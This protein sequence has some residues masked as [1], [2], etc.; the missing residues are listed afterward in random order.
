MILNKKNIEFKWFKGLL[1]YSSNYRKFENTGIRWILGLSG[2]VMV[3]FSLSFAFSSFLF[4]NIFLLFFWIFPYFF[5]IF[6]YFFKI[7]L[8]LK[9]HKN[10]S[11][12]DQWLLI[13]STD[14][15]A[16]NG[17]PGWPGR[18]IEA[19]CKPW[20]RARG[21]TRTFSRQ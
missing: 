6:S 13:W 3:D 17:Q 10:Q 21:N 7:F 8:Y 1:E 14:Q 5:E 2:T 16:V 20:V 15:T 4:T 9:I 19:R 11:Q 12:L 18:W